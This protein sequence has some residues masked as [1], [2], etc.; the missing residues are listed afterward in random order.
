MKEFIKP[1]FSIFS[2]GF[3][4]F[5]ISILLPFNLRN[6]P[7]ILFALLAIYFL[8]QSK[9]NLDP[10]YNA[11]LCINGSYFV[12][13]LCSMFYTENH[14]EGMENIL[15]ISPMVISPLVFYAV[16]TRFSINHERATNFLY[17]GFFYSTVL[18]FLAILIYSY[19]KGFITETYLLHYPERLHVKFGKYSLHP[20]YASMFVVISLIFSAPIIQD[21]KRKTSKFAHLLAVGFL[22]LELLLLARKAA[23]LISAVIFLYYFIYYKNKRGLIYFLAT[24]SVFSILAYTNEFLRGRF[25]E[26]TQTLMALDF[27]NSGSTSTRLQTYS[28]SLDAILKAP[29]FGYGVGDAKDILG[30]YYAQNNRPYYNAHNQFLGAWLSSGIIGAGSLIIILINGFKMA[31]KSRDFIYASVLFLFMSMAFIENILETQTGIL[32]FSFF[33][34]FFAFQGLKNNISTNKNVY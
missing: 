26:F 23:I 7:F 4:L 31:I 33:V 21:L 29:I 19:L 25:V 18:F 11:L 27:K 9:V 30:Q 14:L 5:S 8:G 6:L 34:N 12:A 13:T 22:I 2:V 17:R 1:F 20:L 28:F 3:F 24:L 10:K 16:Y 15:S 32:L